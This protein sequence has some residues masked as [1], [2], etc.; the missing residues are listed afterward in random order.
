MNHIHVF[1]NLTR[2]TTT[3]FYIN[4]DEFE[5]MKGRKAA[6]DKI[7]KW[8][9]KCLALKHTAKSENGNITHTS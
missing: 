1:L 9:Q 5:T 3:H 4:E 2:A 6:D 7:F 8:L